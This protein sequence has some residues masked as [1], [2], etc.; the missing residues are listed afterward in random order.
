MG[1]MEKSTF[2]PE[3][4]ILRAELVAVRKNAGLTQRDV[5][6]RLKVP[7]SWVAKVE[8]GER[9]IDLVE[10]CLFSS[11]CD[12][13]PTSVCSRLSAQI[14]VMQAKRHRKGKRR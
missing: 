9:R 11:A 3:Y 1:T 8:T 13:D 7:P 2:T 12:A 6:R 14:A 4:A 10:M 5:A